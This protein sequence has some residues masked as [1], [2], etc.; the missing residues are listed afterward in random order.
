[1]TD[2]DKNTL[3]LLLCAVGN[4]GGTSVMGNPDQICFQLL[5]GGVCLWNVLYHS[6]RRWV[7]RNVKVEMILGIMFVLAYVVAKIKCLQHTSVILV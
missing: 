5:E 2:T 7:S 3:S 6:H 4:D 1:M